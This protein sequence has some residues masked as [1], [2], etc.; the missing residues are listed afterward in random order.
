M[1]RGFVDELSQDIESILENRIGKD[2]GPGESDLGAV[3]AMTS[4]GCFR[5]RP[6]NN[7]NYILVTPAYMP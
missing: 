2:D 1:L 6:V 7:T 4:E 5:T 3:A